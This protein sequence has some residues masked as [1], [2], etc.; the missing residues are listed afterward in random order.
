MWHYVFECEIRPV[1]AYIKSSNNMLATQ[2]L[3]VTV[4]NTRGSE[5][6]IPPI[7]YL[8]TFIHFWD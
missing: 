3:Q 5:K 2:L 6:K 8:I 4:S 7:F 1:L